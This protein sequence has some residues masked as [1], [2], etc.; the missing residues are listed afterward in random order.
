[1]KQTARVSTTRFWFTLGFA[2][3]ITFMAAGQ[4]FA[5]ALSAE[6]KASLLYMREE[7]KVARD[8]YL[9]LYDKWQLTIFKNISTSEQKHMDAIK[10]LLDRY[11]LKDP[12]LGPGRF[13]NPD[14]Q[15]MY[16]A[17]I[18][19]G[20]VSVVNALNVGVTIEETDIEDLQ[21][22]LAI[23]VHNDIERVYQNL[24]TGSENHL[25]AFQSL[26]TKY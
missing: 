17:L 9:A 2:L 6:E 4:L 3:L 12:A 22:G 14:L 20:N 15:A 19:Q 11:Q 8:V 21:S 24:M 1:M 10:T 18:K 5:A 25:A 23:T 13:T 7:E 16:N 26:L